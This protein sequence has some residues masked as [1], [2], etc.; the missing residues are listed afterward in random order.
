MYYSIYNLYYP[1]KSVCMAKLIKLK[2]MTW[3]HQR[4]YDPMVVTSH[5]FCEKNSNVEIVWHK[6]SLQAFADR[7]LDDMTKEFDLIVIDHPHVGE[8]AAS[9]ILHPFNAAGDAEK[10]KILAEQS[11]GVS[12]KSYEF[13]GNQW[14]LALD[15][16]TPIAAYRPDLLKN[17]PQK[18]DDVVELAKQG[19]VIWPLIPI[20][21]LMSFFNLLANIN[22]AFGKN[23][24]GVEPEVGTYILNQMKMVSNHIPKPCFEMD[25][26]DAYEWLANRSSHSYV[27]LLYGYSNYSRTGFRANLVKATNI[28]CLG[29]DGPKGSPIGGTGIAISKYCKNIAVAKQYAYWVASADCQRNEFYKAGGQ[30][31]N[32]V[33]WQDDGCNLDSHNFFKD[34]LDTLENSYLRPRH[35]GYMGFQNIAGD[36]IFDCLTDKISI[37][38]AVEKINEEYQRSFF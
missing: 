28:A 29:N 14:A 12:H 30:P 6:R 13:D 35:N 19:K 23:K 26:I 18:W 25:P 27:P 7:S 31:A 21:A 15:A 8:A 1:G 36:I 37:D 17:I 22:E 34:T 24:T 2:G 38:I 4:G 5:L 16:A 33:A 32:L 20:N 11:V 3:D 9:K 10:L